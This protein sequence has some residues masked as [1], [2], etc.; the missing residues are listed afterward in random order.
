[1]NDGIEGASKHLDERAHSDLGISLDIIPLCR[2]GKLQSLNLF[3][4]IYYQLKL[5]DPFGHGGFTQE[6]PQLVLSLLS[7]M[8]NLTW[9]PTGLR[10]GVD[11]DRD[12][13][14][15]RFRIRLRRM[16]STT[17][18]RCMGH[19]TAPSPVSSQQSVPTVGAAGLTGSG[20]SGNLAA[21]L[22][23]TQAAAAAMGEDDVCAY[24]QDVCWWFELASQLC[25]HLAPS[26]PPALPRLE[27]STSAIGTFLTRP[28]E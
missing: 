26:S 18:G 15:V 10:N 22:S 24:C 21:L 17:A 5:G 27:L 20:A 6:T 9:M 4:L 13:E 28:G 23:A 14:N 1:M 25:H 12:N 11:K 7:D 3:T 16:A 19:C 8:L 2:V